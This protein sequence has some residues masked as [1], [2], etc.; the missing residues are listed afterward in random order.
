MFRPLLFFFIMTSFSLTQF[1]IAK[2]LY[3]TSVRKAFLKPNGQV[4]WE[5]VLQR[6]TKIKNVKESLASKFYTEEVH[7]K[8]KNMDE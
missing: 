6:W 3:L 7:N 5:V 1:S 2:N 4:D 8:I